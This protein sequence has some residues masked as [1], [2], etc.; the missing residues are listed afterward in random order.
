MGVSSIILGRPLLYDHDATLFGRTNTCAFSHHG[1]KFAISPT[2][3]KDQVKRGSS[4][5]KEKEP[6]VNLIKAKEL[7]KE[8]TE[9]TPATKEI[10]ELT[11]R[12]HPQEIVEALKEFED[13]L[14]DELPNQLSPDEITEGTPA[15][16][17]V[18]ESTKREHP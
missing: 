6:G 18:Q 17:E 3:S 8:I 7:E 11:Q 9:G 13:V 14:P 1:K 16:K 15:T 2:Q 4:S 5:L 10:H 12:E